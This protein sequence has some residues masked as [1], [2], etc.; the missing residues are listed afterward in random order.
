LPQTEPNHW[1]SCILLDES[2]NTEPED[3]RLALERI[4]VESRPIWKPM[5]LQPLYKD[6]SYV[7]VDGDVC[8]YIFERGLCLPSDIKMTEKEQQQIISIIRQ[9]MKGGCDVSEAL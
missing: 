8:K 6:Y 9:T 1:L 3:I 4:N 2:C 7:S 5:H